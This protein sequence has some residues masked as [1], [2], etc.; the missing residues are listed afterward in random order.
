MWIFTVF[1]ILFLLIL[2]VELYDY[3]LGKY[4]KI[5]ELNQFNDLN[6]FDVLSRLKCDNLKIKW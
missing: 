3:I 1:M 2:W 5:E 4:F 6:K